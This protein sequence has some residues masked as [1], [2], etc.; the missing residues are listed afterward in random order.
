MNL[1]D[2]ACPFKFDIHQFRY[3]LLDM[4]TEPY[5]HIPTL[6]YIQRIGED[7]AYKLEEVY[8]KYNETHH[9]RI[10]ETIVID[11]GKACK[12]FGPKAA[13]LAWHADGY[14]GTDILSH[15]MF[16]EDNLTSCLTLMLPLTD[17]G[18]YIYIGHPEM[19]LFLSAIRRIPLFGHLKLIVVSRLNIWQ[20]TSK[21]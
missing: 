9:L 14:T 4:A 6:L 12:V 21:H 10:R 20:K 16:Q 15:D 11:G 1:F 8:F 13:N 5:F 7:A 3:S 2:D 17:A 18:R 19:T